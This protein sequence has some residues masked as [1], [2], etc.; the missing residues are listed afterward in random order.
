MP[1]SNA[2]VTGG[3]R[4]IG[5]SIVRTLSARG[6]KVFVF[7]CL[8]T[9]DS[10]VADLFKNNVSYIQADL[11]SV[12]SIKNGFIQLF[13]KIKTLNLLVNN[14]G[15]T[16]DNLAL[17]LSEKDWDDVLTVNLKGSFFCSQQALKCMIKQPVSYIIF[18]SSIVARL[19][20]PGQAN[21][22][23]SKA[24]LIALTRTLSREYASRNV[25]V[26][27]IAPGFIDTPMTQK[28]SDEIKQ[29]ALEH[30]PLNRFGTGQDVANLV[31]FLSSG[32][33]DY[34]TGQVIEVTG[35][36]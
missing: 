4:G 34:I 11:S 15:I 14:A 24:G 31:D 21:Y 9:S 30:I 33:A 7:D 3:A 29:K 5:R 20:N 17:R 16:R 35:G 19:G 32:R 2:L 22:S 18:I 23:A 36:M 27:A 26:N 1:N 28:L 13:S 8:P 12:D 25:C 6:D 10:L